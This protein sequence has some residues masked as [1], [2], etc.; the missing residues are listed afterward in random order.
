VVFRLHHHQ[1]DR[2]HTRELAERALHWA[3][4]RHVCRTN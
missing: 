3:V 4:S 2:F 1:F